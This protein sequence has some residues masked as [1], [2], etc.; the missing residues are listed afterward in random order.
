M[1]F[2]LFTFF[3]PPYFSFGEGCHYDAQA[4]LKL[5]LFLFPRPPEQHG[6]PHPFLLLSFYV[7]EGAV[8]VVGWRE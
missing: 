4:S 8:V 1:N 3:L 5:V 6:E 7:V 2:F